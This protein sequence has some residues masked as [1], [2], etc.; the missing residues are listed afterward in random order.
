MVLSILV[1]TTT[2]VHMNTVAIAEHKASITHAALYTG[3][4]WEM[5]G[6][7]E[8]VRASWRAWRCAVRVVAVGWAG[9]GCREDN[10]DTR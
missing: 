1:Y 3:G 2:L 4:R 8:E 5:A 6:G 9:H 10:G 7:G